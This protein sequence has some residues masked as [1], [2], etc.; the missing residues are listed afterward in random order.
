[1]TPK[2]LDEK[3]DRTLAAIRRLESRINWLINKVEYR[4]RRVRELGKLRSETLTMKLP[5]E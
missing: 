4:R 1:M 3:L 2:Q 5:L